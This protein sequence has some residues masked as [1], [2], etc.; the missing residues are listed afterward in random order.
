MTNSE[1][2]SRR[3]SE[4]IQKLIEGTEKL[5][6]RQHPCSIAFFMFVGKDGK[7]FCLPMDLA[8]ELPSLEVADPLPYV[9]DTLTTE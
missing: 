6:D 4:L 3:P 7:Q 9:L 1:N 2:P 8:E 5:Q